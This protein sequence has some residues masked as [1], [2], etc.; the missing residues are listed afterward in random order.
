MSVPPRP[1]PCVRSPRVDRVNGWLE[2]AWRRGLCDKPTLNPED[3][4][5]KATRDAP[6]SGEQG[7]RSDADVAD[8]RLRLEALC[9]ALEDTAK[10]NSLGLTMAH[11]Q[12]VRAIRQRLELGALW[13]VEPEILQTPLA[14][15][16][17]VVGHMRSGTT[18]VH[19]L[20]AADPALAATRFCDSWQPVPRSPDT[21]PAWS[22]L[23]LMFA[24][25]LDPWLDSIHPFGVTRAD[26]ELGWLAAALDHCAYEAQWRIPTFTAFSEA[27]DPAPVYREFARMLRTDANWHEN[28]DRPR[29]LKVPQ[30]AED[31]P[32]LLS[33][34]PD[35]RVVLT[36]RC[37]K[38]LARSAASLVANQ[39]AIQSDDVDFDWIQTEMQRKIA[40]R[41]DRM[42]AALESFTGPLSV[43]E[44]EALN[45][46]WE[47]EIARVYNDLGLPLSPEAEKNMREEQARAAN[48][49]HQA[50][51]KTYEAFAQA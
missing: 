14:P 35:A 25:A 44:F 39:M 20:L 13:Q 50:H 42:A 26:E 15:P 28:A 1:H 2:T 27:R 33:Q 8:F 3:L 23:T 36:R 17:I 43:V 24:R 22:A 6:A 48:G 4:W 40:L 41:E 19:R 45:D 12:L 21:R 31:L 47:A 29:V 49:S 5:A 18:R 30:F 7:P 9:A 11:G 10:L 46:D 38:D 34:F 16:V 51:A 37:E 32:A